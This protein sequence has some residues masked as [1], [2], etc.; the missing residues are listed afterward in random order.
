MGPRLSSC[1]L[2]VAVLGQGLPFK[3]SPESDLFNQGEAVR[4]FEEK[5]YEEQRGQLLET[6]LQQARQLR[7]FAEQEPVLALAAAQVL[8]M[9]AWFLPSGEVARD[10]VRASAAL[11]E[12]SIAV[13]GCDVSLSRQ[14]WEESACEIRW[15]HAAMLYTWL[16]ETEGDA[17]MAATYLARGQELLEALRRAPKLAPAA[18]TWRSPLEINFNSAVY[19][20]AP[21]RPIWATSGFAIG[22]WLEE[23][24]PVFRAELEAI[25]AGPNDLYGQLVKLDGS[26]EHL[27]TP[28]GWHTVRIVRY[29]H[30]YE[31]FCALAPRTCELIK[32]RPEINSCSFMNVNYVKLMPGAH[33]KPHF[34][35]APRLSAHLSVIAPEPL[36]AGMGVGGRKRLWLEGKA[37]IFDDTYPH[38]VSHWGNSP[39]YVMLVW[40]CHPCDEG[41]AHGQRCGDLE[42]AASLS[43]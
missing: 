23:Q 38:S 35:N 26:R 41:N 4:F 13:S 25:L 24:Y 10:N 33:L 31:A 19:P 36:R 15:S 3:F 43:G 9:F 21:S 40:F 17:A 2:P 11:F 29:H 18:K 14:E 32:T 12:R 30:W 28:G 16:G 7:L 27:A 42:A 22:K 37:I 39:R 8:Y 6:E 5:F 20:Q 1:F 34:G